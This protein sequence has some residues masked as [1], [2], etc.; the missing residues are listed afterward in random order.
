MKKRF[1]I[2]AIPGLLITIIAGMSGVV[3]SGA[4]RVPAE[5]L[6][7]T[8]YDD[9]VVIANTKVFETLEYP[10]V[11]FDHDKH[12]QVLG[13][14]GKGCDACHP[15][16]G[17]NHNLV[18][19]IFPQ[20]IKDISQTSPKAL[21]HAYHTAC[22]G[23]HEKRL[24]QGKKAGP[25]V[26]GNCHVKGT[27]AAKYTYSGVNFDFK[28]HETHTKKLQMKQIEELQA[29]N[30]ESPVVVKFESDNLKESQKKLIE[31]KAREKN[32]ALCHHQYS[33][34][35]KKM[36]Y[37]VVYKS[38]RETD[39]A[40]A[41]EDCHTIGAQ[42]S[43]LLAAD[44]SVT[45][46]KALTMEKIAHIRCLNCHLIIA[47]AEGADK[48]G[49]TL[50]Y[51][52]HERKSV[53]PAELAKVPRPQAGQPATCSIRVRDAKMKTVPFDHAFHAQQIDSCRACHH[54]T[55]YNCSR[56]H[57]LQGG[58]NGG[59]INVFDAYHDLFSN[60]SCI[61]CHKAEETA[62]DC[63]GCHRQSVV[64]KEPS[65]RMCSRCHNGLSK[66]AMPVTVTT[67]GL[68]PD[69]VKKEIT[70]KELENQFKP[71]KYPHE[72]ILIKLA[73]VSNSSKLAT[74][75]H[76]NIQT[77]C[78]GCHHHGYR[79][80]QIKKDEPPSCVECHSKYFE[81]LAL[82]RPRLLA[83]YH[84]MCIQCHTKMELKKPKA[85][86]DCHAFV[87]TDQAK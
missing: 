77:L 69:V 37:T 70:I 34:E 75:F 8:T 22:I 25:V 39:R 78:E 50:C 16:Y 15:F 82:N 24:E 27:D 74:Y 52:C 7:K 3:H 23:C 9:K 41:C 44:M 59:G 28:L 62:K 76:E 46:R 20:G 36:I 73:G 84:E 71:V 49:P 12:T 4:L 61:G 64:A 87:K 63:S 10:A 26:C 83:A 1:S 79:D 11:I 43:P 19:F 54:E 5:K 51:K 72:K 32:C 45:T 17:K 6:V 60:K 13:K 31:Q 21:M 56:C 53:A 38:G 42:R 48:A 2:I 67:A 55:L 66:V 57:T 40:W 68:N 85:C 14:E 86:A 81:P 30:L 80:V 35:Q 47:K 33:P 18:D 58:V 29:L 65:D